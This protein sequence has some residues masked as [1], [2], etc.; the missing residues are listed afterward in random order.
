MKMIFLNRSAVASLAIGLMAVS[1]VLL[2]TACPPPPGCTSDADCA[3]GEVCNTATG[4]CEAA[5]TGCTSD[6]DCEEGEVCNTETGECEAA[7]AGCT[8]DEDCAEGEICNT[9]TGECEAAP[10]G[11]TSD[12][13]CAENE[14]CDT[15]TGECIVNENLYG[16]TAFD[17]DFD[18]VHPLHTSCMECHHT[19]IPSA[20][21]GDCRTCHSDDPNVANSYKEVAHDD[22]ESGDGCRMCHAAEF[23]DNCAYCHTALND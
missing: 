1:I 18:R 17:T 20:G 19:G 21:Q 8:S 14:F 11:C 4:Q 6:E 12:D 23:E 3:A 9:E 13:D 15:Q 16:T 2:G 5:P 7:P 22:N 10:T